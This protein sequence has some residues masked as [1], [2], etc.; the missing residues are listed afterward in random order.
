MNEAARVPAADPAIVPTISPAALAEVAITGAP[1]AD[2]RIADSPIAPAPAPGATR[3]Q[4][5]VLQHAVYVIGDNPV[6]GLSAIT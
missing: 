2:S 5:S 6:T 1:I 3:K 4:T